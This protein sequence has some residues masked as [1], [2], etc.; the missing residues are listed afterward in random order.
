V[1]TVDREPR[2]GLEVLS[3]VSA[4]DEFTGIRYAR[5]DGKRS[6]A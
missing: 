6:L 5:E 3:S 1:R 2:T 4:S